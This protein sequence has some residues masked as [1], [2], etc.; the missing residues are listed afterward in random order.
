M[1]MMYCDSPPYNCQYNPIELAWAFTKSYY[2]K[3][4]NEEQAKSPHTVRRVWEE[5][6]LHFTPDMWKKS[7]DHCEKIV[8]DDWRQYMGNFSIS[9]IPPIIISLVESDSASEFEWSDSD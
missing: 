8:K 4:I 7:V 3:H 1:G 2:N 6:L 5:A 9:N